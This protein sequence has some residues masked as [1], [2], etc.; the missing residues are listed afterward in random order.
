[1][2][3]FETV[4]ITDDLSEQEPI[5]SYRSRRRSYSKNKKKK[6]S[7]IVPIGKIFG[8][9]FVLFLLTYV[10]ILIYTSNFTMVVTEEAEYQEVSDYLETSAL[11]LRNEEYVE[12]RKDGILAYV[13]E[14]GKNVNVGGTVA[15]LFETESDVNNWQEYNRLSDELNVLEQ[16]RN[17][18][19]NKFIDLDTVDTQIRTNLTNYENSIRS[20]RFDNANTYKLM[21]MQLFNERAVITDSSYDFSDRME[22]LKQQRSA[23]DV[24]DSIGSVRSSVSGTF[25]SALD[26]YEKSVDYSKITSL[27]PQDLQTIGRIDPP[28]NAVGKVITTLNWYFVCEV[29]NEQAQTV[30]AG[31]T[32]V[33]ISIPKVIT[34][35]IPGTVVAVNQESTTDGG[36]LVIRCDYMDSELANIRQEEINI[37]TNTYSGLKVKRKAIHEDTVRVYDYDENGNVIGE[38]RE[39][40]VQGVYVMY[41]NKLSFM[42]VDIVYSGKDFVLCNPAQGNPAL[43]NGETISLHD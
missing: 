17:S 28:K 29:T 27:L 8:V 20:N 10:S 1:M 12:C 30:S 26:G 25:V 11:V 22:T 40:R 37:R 35:T 34:G 23:L 5:T 24:S 14:D 43:A 2:S 33:Q 9:L 41:G 36:V 6:R 4:N 18:E 31:S 16:L 3:E 38:P 13:V 42:Q 19:N 15:K 7:F 32:D 21:L 39:E